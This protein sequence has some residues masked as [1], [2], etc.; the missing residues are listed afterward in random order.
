MK[1]ELS[2]EVKQSQRLNL[3][4]ELRQSIELLQMNSYE[5][6]QHI[7]AEIEENPLLEVKDSKEIDWL[8]FAERLNRGTIRVS[9][10]RDEEEE[11]NHENYIASLPN[12]HD[13]LLAELGTMDLDRRERRV[14]DYIIQRINSDGYFLLDS[15]EAARETR[16]SQEEFLKVLFKV[17]G[18]EPRG[19]AARSL[20]EC[21]ELQIEDQS[22]RAQRTRQIIR[23]DLIQIASR[24]YSELQKKY[25]ISK[26][27]LAWHIDRIKGLDPKPGKK[28]SDFV[29]SFVHPDLILEEKEGCYDLIDSSPLPE[30]Y[31]SS[32]YQSLLKESQDQE[33][34]D[35]VR[36]RLNRALNLIRSINQRRTTIRKVA[37]SIIDY[38]KDFFEEDQAFRPMRLRDIAEITGFHESTISRTVNDKYILT[39]KG[40]F[41]LKDFFEKGIQMDSGQMVAVSSLKDEILFLI[42]AEDKTKPLSDQKISEEMAK[43]DLPIARRTVT[44]YREEMK[45]GPASQRKEL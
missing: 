28:F 7:K 30:L 34:L 15:L 19:M 18:M 32:Y 4:Q 11:P 26:E 1:L 3:T 2:M 5:L 14:A 20:E 29:P 17:Q 43:K 16:V 40:V 25:G 37:S 6:E 21:L 42:E 23:E 39:S 12:L 36:E 27:E 31:I 41:E 45:I 24:K 44:K 8:K 33:V 9:R 35:Y 38:Q 13:H 10:Q 22:E